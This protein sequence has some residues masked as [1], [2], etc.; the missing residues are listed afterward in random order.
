M[1]LLLSVKIGLMTLGEYSLKGNI[2]ESLLL[3]Y[4]LLC[5]QILSDDAVEGNCGKF[6][7]GFKRKLKKFRV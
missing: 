4:H 5:H 2:A 1:R 6:H 7:E 3:F